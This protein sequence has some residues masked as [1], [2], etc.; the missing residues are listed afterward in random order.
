MVVLGTVGDK[1]FGTYK[2]HCISTKMDLDPSKWD[3]RRR[4][5]KGANPINKVLDNIEKL[6]RDVYF[7]Y[8]KTAAGDPELMLS[9]IKTLV[10]GFPSKVRD[11]VF[12]ENEIIPSWKD[13]TLPVVTGDAVQILE[14]KTAYDN[15]QSEKDRILSMNLLEYIKN[16]YLVKRTDLEKSSVKSYSNI[17]AF[18]RAYNKDSKVSDLTEEWVMDFMRWSRKRRKPDG[19]LYGYNYINTCIQKQLKAICNY[20]K[21]YEKISIDISW[22][23]KDIRKSGT[24][25]DEIALNLSQLKTI[26]KLDLSGARKR[27]KDMHSLELARD[28]MIIGCLTSLRVSDIKKLNLVKDGKDKFQLDMI[29]Q[30][31]KAHVKFIVHPLVGKI[32]EKYNGK[33]PAMSDQKLNKRVKEIG[34]IAFES[35]YLDFGKVLIIKK[36]DPDNKSKIIKTESIKFYERIKTSSFRRTWAS[37]AVQSK[38]MSLDQI[39]LVTGHSR[40]SQLMEYCKTSEDDLNEKLATLYKKIKL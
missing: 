21:T 29:T 38:L 33:I 8:Y 12:K 26:I 15:K 28:L 34:K 5:A 20:I 1:S 17:Q 39:C 14:K 32:Y 7:Q 30:K 13:S 31:T 23:N 19:E 27:P 24:P 2:S 16:E 4:R 40:I 3:S 37:Y 22:K 36:I 10:F 35:G 18:I 25:T 11:V 6:T 9:A